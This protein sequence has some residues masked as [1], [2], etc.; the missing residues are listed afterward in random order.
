ML[1]FK[2]LHMYMAHLVSDYKG[3]GCFCQM[4]HLLRIFFAVAYSFLRLASG[5]QVDYKYQNILLLQQKSLLW[6]NEPW[7]S[8][9]SY[10]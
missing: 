4:F 9:W 8:L 2:N 10:F 1:F 6:L 5:N 7:C 3:G